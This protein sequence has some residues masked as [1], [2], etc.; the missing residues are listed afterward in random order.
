MDWKRSKE[1]QK[2]IITS[3]D[4]VALYPNLRIERCAVEVGK[5]MEESEIEY[6]N[7]NYELGGKF[8]AS[9]MTQVDIDREGLGRIVPRRK[10]K[11]GTRPGGTTQELYDRRTF[12]EE[13][14]EVMKET[15]R[16]KVRETLTQRDIRRCC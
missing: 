1:G 3:M 6:E 2:I 9:N 8:I 4:V 5:E 15:K 16:S 7:V 10:S 14:E 13:G 12:N 11:F